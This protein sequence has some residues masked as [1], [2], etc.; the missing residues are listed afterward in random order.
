MATRTEIANLAL[1]MLGS[2]AT[3]Q[4]IDDDNSV[5]ARQARLHYDQA[6]KRV[7]AA[8]AW[9]FSTTWATSALHASDPPGDWTYMYAMPADA[10]KIL[11]VVDTAGRVRAPVPFTRAM[12]NGQQVLLTDHE[13]PVW[14]YIFVNED[15][16]TYSPEFIDALVA[17]L[18]ARL[19]MPL[20]RKRELAKDASD[21]YE[22]AVRRASAADA[23]ENNQNGE[24]EYKPE[25][26]EAR[27][28]NPYDSVYTTDA[29]GNIIEI[30]GSL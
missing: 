26:H 19:A 29:D 14:R 10:L 6:L 20:T 12:Y 13:S 24:D 17:S 8:S 5:E 21:Q 2:K 3:I 11:G 22:L 27:D 25:W 30:P 9:T 1:S 15:P 4:D 23:N 18:A 28:Y 16:V 7:L